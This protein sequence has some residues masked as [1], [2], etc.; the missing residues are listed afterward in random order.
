MRYIAFGLAI[1]YGLAILVAAV[2]TVAFGYLPRDATASHNETHDAMNVYELQTT[3]G[4]AP[5]RKSLT[6]SIGSTAKPF[7]G[8]A[9][10][11]SVTE[12]PAIVL[13]GRPPHDAHCP[14]LRPTQ[15]RDRG[16]SF[17]K[18]KAVTI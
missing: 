9:V 18:A 13:S 16:F 2:F 14:G 3:E 6:R 12:S 10:N 11:L 7:T 17:L 1:A 4:S 5:D 8:R 15:Q